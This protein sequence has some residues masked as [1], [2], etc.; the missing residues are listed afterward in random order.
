MGRRMQDHQRAYKKAPD[1]K[2]CPTRKVRHEVQGDAL[3]AALSASLSYGHPMRA[4]QCYRCRGWHLTSQPKS[5]PVRGSESVP[6]VET[7]EG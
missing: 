5:Q 4:Y 3:D 7:P 1:R 6:P 2:M